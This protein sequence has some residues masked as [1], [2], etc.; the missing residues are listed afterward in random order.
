MAEKNY[1]KGIF[2][3]EV[4]NYGHLNVNIKLTDFI[5]QVKP[6]VG[7]KGYVNLTIAKKKEAGKY[8]DT[9]YCI[10]NTW[11]PE[12]KPTTENNSEIEEDDTMPF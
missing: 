7:E 6:L 3:K 12:A 10:E 4:G 8:G 2:I 9:H 1:I 11:K 5:E